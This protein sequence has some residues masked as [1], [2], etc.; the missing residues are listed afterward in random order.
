MLW[1]GQKLFVQIFFTAGVL[2]NPLKVK[3]PGKPLD[4]RFFGSKYGSLYK[5]EGKF[6][7][8]GSQNF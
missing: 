8:V 1:N 3:R 4:S 2:K 5:P 7:N 6:Y